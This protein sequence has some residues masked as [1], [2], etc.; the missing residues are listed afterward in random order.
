M[1]NLSLKRI[2]LISILGL[3]ACGGDD[4]TVTTPTPPKEKPPPVTYVTIKGTAISRDILSDATVTA[5]CKDDSGFKFVVKTD[6]KGN[7]EGQVKSDQLPCR[8]KVTKNDHVN[9]THYSVIFKSTDHINI[10]P[11]TDLAIVFRP[12]YSYLPSGL[13]QMKGS[14]INYTTLHR[15]LNDNNDILV[16]RLIGIGYDIDPS[17]QLFTDI[18]D[19]D[20]NMIENIKGFLIAVNLVMGEYSSYVKT[21]YNGS[22]I[23]RKVAVNNPVVFPNLD[24]CKPGPTPDIYTNCSTDVLG[25]F[26]VNDLITSDRKTTCAFEK[27]GTDIQ[28]IGNN[29]KLVPNE[30]VLST[31]YMVGG[32]YNNAVK[33]SD[34]GYKLSAYIQVFVPVMNGTAYRLDLSITKQ[35]KIDGISVTKYDGYLSPIEYS[36]DEHSVIKFPDE[37]ICGLD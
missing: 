4:S 26:A 2:G 3:S 13:Y 29:M 28:Y 9:M 33:I 22:Y 5:R 32:Y 14:G 37:Y 15:N 25:D 1:S 6:E 34:K 7:W 23:P 8:L 30:E 31:I 21:L 11:F 24:A 12:G 10:S 20:G 27:K 35:G 16:E 19:L 17:A 36:L 18:V